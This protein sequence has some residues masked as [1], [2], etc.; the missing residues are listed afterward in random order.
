MKRAV[1][2][3]GL[4]LMGRRLARRLLDTGWAVTVWNRSVGPAEELVAAGAIGA[5]T[6]ATAASNADLVITA[7]TDGTAVRHVLGDLASG[8]AR[9]GLVVDMSSTSPA[10][11][12]LISAMIGRS[13]K[14]FLDA[15]VS[16]GTTGAETGSLALFVGGDPSDFALATPLLETLGRPVYFGPVGSGQAAKLA[17]QILV[18]V[19]IGGV[20]EAVAFARAVGLDPAKLMETMGLGLAGGRVLES[21]GAR[22]LAGDFAARGRASTHLKDL[23]NAAAE[24]GK[25]AEGM[26]LMRGAANLLTDVVKS[27]GDIDHAAMILAVEAAMVRASQRSDW[28][29]S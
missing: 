17:N 8:P 26:A 25:A 3:L 23:R 2:V 5:S 29:T 6:P 28:S 20:A 12:R 1:T 14:G 13:G 10:E 9:P 16:G 19:T 4:G 7:L 22:M 18:G 15:P 24:I 11:A 27:H 21:V